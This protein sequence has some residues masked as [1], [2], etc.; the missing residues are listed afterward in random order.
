MAGET[1]NAVLLRGVQSLFGFG[2]VRDL[3]DHQLLERFLTADRGEAEAA[4]TFLVQRHGPMV[5]HVCRQVLDDSHDAQDA[6]Q[7]TFLVLL[8][9]ARSIRSRDSLASWLFGVAMR[10]ARRARLYR[11]C[12]A[13]SRAKGR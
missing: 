6:F 12:A 8:R 4:F 9:R 2:V 3:S 10:V 5:L 11:D 1:K 7:A 13:V